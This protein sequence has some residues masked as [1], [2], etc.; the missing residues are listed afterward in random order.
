MIRRLTRRQNPA[1]SRL[2]SE[3]AMPG[4]PPKNANEPPPAAARALLQRAQRAGFDPWRVAVALGLPAAI[5]DAL[6]DELRPDA[7]TSRRLD[8]PGGA[9]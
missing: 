8:P 5:R 7:G 1:T 6:L 4:Q 3:Q 9:R 2:V